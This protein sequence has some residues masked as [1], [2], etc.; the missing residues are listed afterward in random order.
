MNKRSRNLALVAVVALGLVACNRSTNP[1]TSAPKEAAAPPVATVNGKP[2]AA[3]SFEMWVEGVTQRKPSDLTPEQRKKALE[4]LVS[5]YVAADEAEKQGLGR[6]PETAARIDLDR[7]Q[8]LANALI[9][10][11]MKANEPTEATLKT[12]YDKLV[13]DGTLA[14]RKVRH[15]LVAKEDLAKDLIS[16]LEKGGNFDALAKKYSTDGGSKG[17]GGDLGWLGGPALGQM[18]PE[19]T[20]AVRQ[21]NKGE[22]TKAPVQSQFGYHVIQVEDT[23]AVPM[24]AIKEQLSRMVQQKQVTEYMEGLKKTAKIEE[25]L[26]PEPAAATPPAGAP[27]PGTEPV[28]APAAGAAPEAAPPQQ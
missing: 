20:A 1:P 14:E 2:I 5:I 8:A 16:Q 4:A 27:A 24:D 3:K 11:K 26:P 18:V 21:L 28:P 9:Q 25:K 19:F 10:T 15:I 22:T 13:A 17:Q 23:R 12:E 6:E 7:R